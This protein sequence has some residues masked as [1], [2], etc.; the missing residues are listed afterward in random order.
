MGRPV[1][2]ILGEYDALPGLSQKA[3]PW[4]E[5]LKSGAPGHG[6]GHNIFG[7]AS[8][9]GAIVAKVAME[10]S[11][12]EG[13]LRY[14]GCPAEEI[15]VGKVFM[16]R[17][18]LFNDVDAV[19]NYHPSQH[20]TCSM[21]SSN[22]LNSVKFH[23]YGAA[24]HA[25]GSPDQGRSALDAVE[26]M[27]MGVNY[28][29]EHVIQE[30]RI[31]YVVEDGGSEPNVVP[32]YAR[33][34]Y[35]IRAPERE[36][37]DHIYNR[38]LE[39]AEGADLMARTS[40]KVEFITGCYNLIPNETL[41]TLG[42]KVMREIGAPTYNDDE[43][44]F[45]EK[46]SKSIPVEE[47][48]TALKK[49]KVPEWERLVEINLDSRVLDPWNAGEVM[50][51]STDVGDVSWQSP[52][53]SFTTTCFVLGAPGHSWQNV[54]TS[55]M[56]IGHKGLKFAAKVIASSSLELLT[57]PKMLKDAWKE[58]KE[59]KKDKRYVSPISMDQRPPVHLLEKIKET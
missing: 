51:A 15:V 28:L 7:A 49:S 38:I 52:T 4:K 36:Q 58:F 23:F 54:A 39:I 21:S 43:L 30:A 55:G 29:R 47:K 57:K 27:N 44:K 53:L 56:S 25:A 31:H 33:S 20:N 19:I 59:R 3:V 34:W 42:L 37:V 24:S 40:H 13:T 6:C 14:Y 1:I 48:K 2:A 32:P 5:P 12:I 46:L 10:S 22:A 16:V 35:Y 17:D 45:A 26:L 18:G 11:G 50:P 9:A 8:M 41:N